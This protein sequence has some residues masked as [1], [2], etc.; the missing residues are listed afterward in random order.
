MRL[1]SPPILIETDQ[2]PNDLVTDEASESHSTDENQEH[3][4]P[5]NVLLVASFPATSDSPSLPFRVQDRW[6]HS[7]RDAVKEEQ[8]HAPP[9]SSVTVYPFARQSEDSPRNI[10]ASEREQISTLNL[11]SHSSLY[12]RSLLWATDRDD[13][14]FSLRNRSLPSTPEKGSQPSTMSPQ[15]LSASMLGKSK[16]LN[17]LPSSDSL[18]SI[19]SSHM[20]FS[21]HMVSGNDVGDMDV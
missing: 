9:K 18:S 4:L 17:S 19:S 5:S 21:R 16:S 8:T 1:S 13:S 10:S 15:T 3:V 12:D 11:S 6:D 2:K 20:R 14:L 7:K